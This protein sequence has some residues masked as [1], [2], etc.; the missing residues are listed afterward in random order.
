M[1]EGEREGGSEA[2]PLRA[3][4][5]DV[6][7]VGEDDALRGEETALFA[8]AAEREAGR[9]RAV[10]HDDAVARYRIRVGTGARV[11]MER[12]TDISRRLRAADHGR[13]LAI[14]RDLAAGYAAYDIEDRI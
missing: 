5:V 2:D 11:G 3:G 13:D 9:E 6:G 8:G 14:C 1:Q 4:H 7:V 10:L 12:E